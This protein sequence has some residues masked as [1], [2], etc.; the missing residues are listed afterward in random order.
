MLT[1]ETTTLPLEP[2]FCKAG[3]SEVF[4]ND[5]IASS[6]GLVY[7]D[8]NVPSGEFVEPAAV[9]GVW[10]VDV[11]GFFRKL[12]N[13]AFGFAEKNPE[14]DWAPFGA[15]PVVPAVLGNVPVVGELRL[16]FL[17][18]MR[19]PAGLTTAA[20]F[21]AGAVDALLAPPAV[22]EVPFDGAVEVSSF[23]FLVRSS[24]EVIRMVKVRQ[25]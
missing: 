11:I 8:A 3:E 19:T 16:S 10:V 9:D 22:V 21:V 25:I 5:F 2:T 18:A 24:G 15:L 13:L 7:V 23:R 4:R 1:P 17:T 6:N 12:G 14:S 20:F